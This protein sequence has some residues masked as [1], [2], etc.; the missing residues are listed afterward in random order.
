MRRSLFQFAV[1]RALCR[2]ASDAEPPIEETRRRRIMTMASHSIML[3][4]PRKRESSAWET[5]LDARFRGHDKKRCGSSAI[6]SAADRSLIRDPPEALF[7]PEHREHVEDARRGRTPG[8]R[9]AQRLSDDSQ[10]CAFLFAVGADDTLRACR[11]P[12]C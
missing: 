3:S 9:R 11:R 6:W 10:L 12:L 1:E 2:S 8:E 7:A 4:F 5:F